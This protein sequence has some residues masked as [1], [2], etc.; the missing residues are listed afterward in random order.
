[1]IA[2]DA[3]HTGLA[4]VFSAMI[5]TS[6]HFK[7]SA[8]L[9]EALKNVKQ[10]YIKRKAPA[11]KTLP[12]K[13]GRRRAVTDTAISGKTRD[14][15]MKEYINKYRNRGELLM[16]IDNYTKRENQFAGEIK[17]ERFELARMKIVYDS[18]NEKNRLVKAMIDSMK[19]RIAGMTK[20]KTGAGIPA[21][22]KIAKEQKNP[23]PLT[24]SPVPA[25]T[26]STTQ[27]NKTPDSTTITPA[28][29][30]ADSIK[31]KANRRNQF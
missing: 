31:E 20:G 8:A 17:K 15:A 16:A 25:K 30:P 24:T 22:K 14:A 3:A 27:K 7:T 26:D 12:E 23:E 2:L 11:G 28:P 29:A 6:E 13:A 1:M 19:A 9:P 5:D 21:A 4:A 18:I 10:E